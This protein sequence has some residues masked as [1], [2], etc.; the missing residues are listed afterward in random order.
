MLARRLMKPTSSA[1]EIG[2]Q[3]FER[4]WNQRDS[5]A[6]EELMAPDAVGHLEGGHT[7][8]GPKA[9]LKFQ[10][11]FLDAVPDMHLTVIDTVADKTNVCVYWQASGSHTGRGLGFQPTHAALG[12]QGVTWFKVQAG[13][14]VDGRD[15]WNMAALMQKMSLATADDLC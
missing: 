2:I 8:V 12:F 3:W 6:A 9:F 15:F 13:R 4:V 14:I 5:A 11:G 10:R 1:R 7:I